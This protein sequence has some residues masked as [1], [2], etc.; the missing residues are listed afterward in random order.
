[1][2]ERLI[3]AIEIFQVAPIR[4]HQVLLGK[5]LGYTLFIGMMSGLLAAGLVFLGVPVPTD[6]QRLAIYAG[7]LLLQ[8]LAAVGLGFLISVVS[9]SDSQAIQLSMLVLLMSIF[10]SGFFL[11]LENF[12]PVVRG[13]GYLLP[14]SHGIIGL[15]AI[16]LDNHVPPYYSWL[17]LGLITVISFGVAAR[18]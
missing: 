13:I 1:V 5:Y 12:L 4:P 14:I 3:G 16:L 8:I 10:F 9:N 18:G 2:R 11:P 17:G 6:E 7:F 15:H